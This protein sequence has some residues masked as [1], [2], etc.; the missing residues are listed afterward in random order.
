MSCEKGSGHGGQGLF[1]GEES[2]TVGELCGSQK[3]FLG[4]SGLFQR[5]GAARCF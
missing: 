3:L 1:S 2:S 4:K 5:E